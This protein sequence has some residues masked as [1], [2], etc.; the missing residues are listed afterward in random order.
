MMS[1]EGK[2]SPL[3][4]SRA[5][6]LNPYHRPSIHSPAPQSISPA[7]P[8]YPGQRPSV[9]VVAQR[10]VCSYKTYRHIYQ[11]APNQWLHRGQYQ[12]L[13]GVKGWIFGPL[14]ALHTSSPARHV[15]YGNSSTSLG[16]ILQL[17]TALYRWATAVLTARQQCHLNNLSTTPAYIKVVSL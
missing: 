8:T 15:H 11:H 5:P 16:S 9:S 7:P 12:N 6:P 10:S 13:F 1:N 4:E 3:H 14:K 17:S 2:N